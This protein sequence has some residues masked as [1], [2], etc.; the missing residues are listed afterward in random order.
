VTICYVV[1]GVLSTVTEVSYHRDQQ[2][3]HSVSNPG[4]S[5]HNAKARIWRRPNR[6]TDQKFTILPHG[7][8]IP[9]DGTTTTTTTATWQWRPPTVRV[10][11]G[12]LTRPTERPNERPLAAELFIISVARRNNSDADDDKDAF[13]NEQITRRSAQPAMTLDLLNANQAR[14]H[15]GPTRCF[16][17]LN[18]SLIQHS[19]SLH[20]YLRVH[21]WRQHGS[22]AQHAVAEAIFSCSGTDSYPETGQSQ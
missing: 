11:V 4:A 5:S 19:T 2:K 3:S 14:S 9:V 20:S 13:P 16:C 18:T 21:H 22:Q 12:K 8:F 6:T 10:A 17:Q 15:T 7:R 1:V